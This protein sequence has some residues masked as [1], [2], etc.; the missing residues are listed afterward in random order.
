MVETADP[1]TISLI[2]IGIWYCL[3]VGVILKRR[4]LREW[5]AGLLV[6]YAVISSLWTLIQAFSRL[7]WMA[8]LADDVPARALLYGLPLLSLLFFHLS[9]SFLRVEGA[10]RTW[11]GL[12]VAWIAAVVVL[13]ENLLALPETMWI[14]PGLVFQRQQAPFWVMVVGWGVSMGG[15]TALTARVYRRTQQPLHRNR[16]KYWS[17]AVGL[18]V[19]GAGL[20][21]GGHETLGSGFHL[22][23]TVSATYAV[24]TYRLPDVRQMGR[25]TVSYLIMT[26]LTVIVYTA[27]FVATQTVF[28]SVPGYSPVLAGATMALIL[29]ILFDPLLSLIQR[30]VNRLM[31]TTRYDPSLTLREYSMNISNIL[32]L[33]RL[34]RVAVGLISEAIGIQH[35]ALFVVHHQDGESEGRDGA[36]C[37]RLQ[38]V[39]GMGKASSLNVLSADSPVAD[40]LRREH[41]PLTQYDVD[42]LPRFQDG[43]P[44]ERTWLSSL[45]MDVYVP[46]IAKGEWIGLLALGRKISGDRYFEDDLTLLSTLAD[47]TAV[48]LENARLFEDLK[49]RNAENE[50]LNEELTTANSELARLDQAK[51]N[52]IDIAS[53]ELRT[54]LTQVRGY[55]EIICDMIEEGSLDPEAGAQMTRGVRKGV[56]RLEEIV[57]L[58]FD[59]SQIDTETMVLNPSRTP[60]AAIVRMAVDTWA[61]ALEERRQTLSVEGLEDLPPITAD[62]KRLKQVFSHL[63]QNAIKYTPDGG[64]VRITGRVLD[65]EMPLEDQTVEIVVADTGI[66]IAPDDL[67]RIFKKFYR[68]GDVLTHST[69]RTKFKGAGPG[70]GL[71]IVRGIVEAHGGRIWA[72]SSGYD[73]H[74]RPGSQF[75]IVLPVQPP[76]LESGG[77]ETFMAAMRVDTDPVGMTI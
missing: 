35:G 23:G 19:V 62:G 36:G 6:L 18:T 29:A 58:M 40:Y 26:L 44:E 14:G 8:T 27:G 48:A 51:S 47:Q 3:V 68:A 22:L 53:H 11:W 67:G 66:G 31:S 7:G 41:R 30:L 21:F 25:R 34:A 77:L 43:P 45:D 13:N 76:C 70:L 54:P 63:I 9:R 16:L 28:Q 65:A 24:V 74:M 32:D 60:V 39:M 49:L 4:G 72:E 12:G 38:D 17:L 71:T 56:Q 75:H 46:I 2:V 73:E 64:H 55:N 10:G 20:L 5:A 69:G 15:A 50:R 52:F 33:E 1:M 37:F 61:K 42:L 57:D 59:V